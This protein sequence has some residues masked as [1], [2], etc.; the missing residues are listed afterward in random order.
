MTI[1]RL[2]PFLVVAY[3][4]IASIAVGVLVN[5]ISKSNGDVGKPGKKRDGHRLELIVNST[6]ADSASI[7]Y[8][9]PGSDPI[10][11]SQHHKARLPWSKT[12]SGVPPLQIGFNLK[13]VQSGAGRLTCIVKLDGDV[14]E[15]KST[16]G[17]SAI[18]TCSP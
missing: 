5:G 11:I 1:L 3:L 15:R 8:V 17:Q 12:F 10:E 4:A 14:I 9:T 7:S 13:A 18:V 2:H 16:R 6:E